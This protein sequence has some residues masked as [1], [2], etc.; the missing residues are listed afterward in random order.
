M[1]DCLYKITVHNITYTCIRNTI[2]CVAG[3]DLLLQCPQGCLGDMA[4]VDL[5]LLV[6]QGTPVHSQYSC[7]L[8]SY[9]FRPTPQLLYHQLS[10]NMA[11]HKHLC[12]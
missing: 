12:I 10:M 8:H 5:A 2:K 11:V 3:F 7:S 6:V 1:C 4:R 9:A